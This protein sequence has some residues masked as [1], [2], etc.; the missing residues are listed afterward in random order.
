MKHLTTRL[1]PSA[2]LLLAMGGCCTVATAPPHSRA[3][4]DATPGFNHR[5][6]ESILTP[7]EVETPI[8]TMRF[9]DGFPD[10]ATVELAYDNLDRS[11]AMEAFLDFV[12]MA[13]LEAL[14]LGQESLGATKPN[15][16]LVFSDLMILGMAFPNVLGVVLLSGKVKG[17]FQD[18]WAKLK[19]GEI[20][21][22][23]PGQET[24][25]TA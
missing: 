21:P 6:P 2:I 5:I 11:R 15:Q 20:R 3:S 18:Y 22:Y 12:P 24:G 16:V 7:D 25:K 10:E 4:E 8:G 1:A 17:A 14:R 19:S 23:E 9:F 13:S